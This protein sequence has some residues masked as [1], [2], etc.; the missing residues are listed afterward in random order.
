[1]SSSVTIPKLGLTMDEAN[2]VE[3][4]RADGEKVAIGDTLLTIETDKVMFD[5]EAEVEGFLQRVAAIGDRLPVGG[6]VAYLHPTEEAARAA[7]SAAPGEIAGPRPTAS[8]RTP[9]AAVQPGGVEAE[10]PSENKAVAPH[11]ASLVSGIQAGTRRLL[12]SPVARRLAAE[13]RID[14]HNLPPSGPGGVILKRDVL[15]AGATSVHPRSTSVVTAG[16]AASTRRPMSAMRRAIAQRM[17]NSLSDTAQMT[18]FGKI[19]M[20]E[21]VKLR[22]TLVA[23]ERELGIRITY[24]DIVLKVVASVLAEMPQI[25]AYIDGDDVVA[26]SEVNLGLAVALDDGLIVPVIHCANQLSLLEISH[27]R[28]ALIDKARSGKLTHEDVARGSFTVSN[29]G[30]YGGDFETPILNSQQSAL[31]GIGEIADQPVIVAQE[32]CIRPI[33]PISLTFDHRL[34]DGAVAGKF[35]SR[36]KALIESPPLLLASLR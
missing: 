1:M 31:L 4:H 3:W 18:G 23:A 11:P 6:L 9:P 7:G 16:A 29:F 32:I 15:A 25:N 5:I 12:A 13:R 8:Y 34:I 10:D 17:H 14:L 28:R 24:T 26:W 20:S 19:D 22:A 27:A 2:L 33:M 35:R 36:I 30:S 21:A